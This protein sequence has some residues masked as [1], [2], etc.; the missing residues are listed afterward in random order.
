MVPMM[1]SLKKTRVTVLSGDGIGPEVSMAAMK[2][3]DAAA[4]PVEWEMAVAGQEAFA[5]GVDSGVPTETLD[6]ITQ[7]KVVLK[8]PLATPIGYG[9]KSANVTLRKFFETFANIRPARELPNVPSAFAGRG[10]DLVIIRENVEDLYAGIEHMQ[11]PNVAQCL[12]LISRLGS[13]R[14]AQAAFDYALA[15]ERKKIT[16]ATKANI[17]KLTEGLFKE[18]FE[19]IASKH[20]AITSEHMLIDNC[21]HQLVIK[22]EQFDVIV[23]TNMNG[24][25]LSDLASGLVGGLGFAPSANLGYQ[26]AIFEAV[27]GTAPDLAGRGLANPTAMILSAVMMLRHIGAFDSAAKIEGALLGTLESGIHT[28]DISPIESVSTQEFTDHVISRLSNQTELKK[29]TNKPLNLKVVD[30]EETDYS[31][32]ARKKKGADIFIESS[33]PPA[34]IAER[35]QH[36]IVGTPY[37]LKMIS[38]RGT[39]VWPV[40]GATP[41]LVDHYR[42]RFLIDNEALWHSDSILGLLER[43]GT[44]FRWMH[45]EKLENL[46][47]RDVFTKAQGEN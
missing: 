16:V 30:S 45:V 24:D 44:K 43:V 10:I 41:S 11:T 13:S 36:L 8:G 3:L 38:N 35:L 32:A 22:P 7:N 23:T 4:A 47:G 18:E 31:P 20:S 9:Q 6:S 28:S 17:M 42:C 46:D 19:K 33:E 1:E 29:R 2:V 26:V 37:K 27:H 25:I 5:Q 21:A 39:Q 15:D 12:K 40:T 34:M 14:I